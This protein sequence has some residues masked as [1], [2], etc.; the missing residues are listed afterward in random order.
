MFS[1]LGD[2]FLLVPLLTWSLD[3]WKGIISRG[4]VHYFVFWTITLTWCWFFRKGFELF[5]L[6][7]CIFW[8]HYTYLILGFFKRYTIF[9][10][11]AFTKEKFADTQIDRGGL[12]K[13]VLLKNV[14]TMPLSTTLSSPSPLTNGFNS[15]KQIQFCSPPLLLSSPLFCS[16]SPL[17]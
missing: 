13:S 4:I 14:G 11:S 7:C 6:V 15:G 3:F 16:S 1:W 17:L 12:I 5:F 8:C 10:F 2:C 9:F